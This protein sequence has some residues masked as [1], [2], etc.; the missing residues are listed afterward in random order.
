MHG[1]GP[2]HP[3]RAQHHP[4]G[5]LSPEPGREGREGVLGTQSCFPWANSENPGGAG[6]GQGR[7]GSPC[8]ALQLFYTSGSRPRSRVRAALGF[9][10]GRAGASLQKALI[11]PG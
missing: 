8:A 6:L 3:P 10:Q 7:L 5:L 4:G 9:F 1:V 2:W 11:I